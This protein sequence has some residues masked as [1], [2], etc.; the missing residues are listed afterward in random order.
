V[1]GTPLVEEWSRY[2]VHNV[3]IYI[4]YM[5]IYIYVYIYGGKAVGEKSLG[6]NRGKWDAGFR[7]P[8]S[9]PVSLMHHP[10]LKCQCGSVKVEGFHPHLGG[11]VTV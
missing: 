7:S 11:S 1:S 5:Y 9:G 2:P 6:E 8:F 4:I 3:Y 10:F